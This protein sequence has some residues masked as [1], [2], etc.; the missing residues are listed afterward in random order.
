[1]NIIFKILKL[2]FV[3]LLSINM[4][5]AYITRKVPCFVQLRNA[6]SSS[7]RH[8][9]KARMDNRYESRSSQ[10]GNVPNLNFKTTIKIDPDLKKSLSEIPISD[11]TLAVLT[12]KGFT[13]LTPIQSQ[14]FEYIA[15]GDD[16]VARS[17]TGTGKTLAF[18]IPLVE[19]L[20]KKDVPRNRRNFSPIVIVLEPTRELAIQ[21]A[22]ELSYLC[23]P[24]GLRVSAIFGGSSFAQQEDEF[25]NGVHIVVATPG[26]LLDHISRRTINLKDIEHVVLDEG[27]TMLEMG[28]QDDVESILMSVK[29]P[30]EISYQV[31]SRQLEKDSDGYGSKPSAD[32]GDS[33]FAVDMDRKIQMLLFSATMPGWICKITD[34]LMKNSIFLDCV[35]DGETRLASSISH[36]C[37]LLPGDMNRFDA[38]ASYAED[39]ILTRGGGGQTIIFTNTKEEA[40]KLSSSRCFGHLKSQV[41]HGDISQVTRQR[42]LRQFREK[43]IDVLVATDVAA[44]GL[45]IAGVDLVVHTSPPRD[46]DSYVHRSGRTGRAGRSGNAVV[47]YTRTES[48]ALKMLEN[49]LLFTFQR[50]GPPSP[51]DLSTASTLYSINK[52]AAIDEGVVKYFLPEAKLV[53]E[54]ALNG[55]L[56]SAEYN[57][58]T[59]DNVSPSNKESVIE[60]LIAR[61]IISISHRQTLTSRSLLTGQ[62]GFLTLKLVGSFAD[63][64]APQDS[65]GWNR[66]LKL[67]L[68]KMLKIE[69]FENVERFEKQ[70]IGKMIQAID[71]KTRKTVLLVDVEYELGNQIIK[72]ALQDQ[73]VK[74]VVVERCDKLPERVFWG[75][76]NREGESNSKFSSDSRRNSYRDRQSVDRYPN[77]Q[78]SNR[79]R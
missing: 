67:F 60:E 51:Q 1:M 12:N 23:K 2:T 13:Q 6:F 17:K 28:F 48:Q 59:E 39:V 30:A 44:R 33:N 8:V 38:V 42:T 56:W 16:V 24:H 29:V 3:F 7:H 18:G 71:D 50:I 47:F 76:P 27:D 64:K 62:E 31:A 58:R 9:R 43:E 45:D 20:I 55:N 26:R 37:L 74:H 36:Y 79:N 66:F 53:L 57:L 5:V 34:K 14:A 15:N 72:L 19:T 61:C 21:V 68:V 75:S 32:T 78:Y 49:K 46:E 22:Q 11:K 41:L 10:F 77:K 54:K 52:L 70:D 35:Q 4:L 25:R 40:D 63:G 65:A 73:I 69:R